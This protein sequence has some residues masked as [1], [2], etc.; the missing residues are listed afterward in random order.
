MWFFKND[1]EVCKSHAPPQRSFVLLVGVRKCHKNKLKYQAKQ[2]L[3]VTWSPQVLLFIVHS[4]FNR[5]PDVIL[6]D[7]TQTLARCPRIFIWFHHTHISSSQIPN[8]E[9]VWSKVLVLTVWLVLSLI[10]NRSHRTIGNVYDRSPA[11][12]VSIRVKSYPSLRN[13]VHLAAPC[14]SVLHIL[15][16]LQMLDDP[17]Q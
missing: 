3:H 4:V 7:K 9:T 12:S 16:S 17:C 15:C 11:C 2:Q 10:P 14:W 13:C 5:K 6:S 1:F 8:E